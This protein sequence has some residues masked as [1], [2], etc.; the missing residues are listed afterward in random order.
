MKIQYLLSTIIICLAGCQN[1]SS[2]EQILPEYNPE[3][4]CY[5]TVINNGVSAVELDRSR[6]RNLYCLS[7]SSPSSVSI[8]P[9]E[10]KTIPI[11]IEVPQVIRGMLANKEVKFFTYPNDTTRLITD[12]Q[13]IELE[14]KYTIENAYLEN[15][16]KLRRELDEENAQWLNQDSLS[17]DGAIQLLKKTYNTEINLLHDTQGLN[18][19]FRSTALLDAQYSAFNMY[20][21][22]MNSLSRR[23]KNKNSKYSP[24]NFPFLDSL[25]LKNPYMVYSDRALE[26]IH[27][28][29]TDLNISFANSQYQ[30]E[31]AAGSSKPNSSKSYFFIDLLQLDTALVKMLGERNY[32]YFNLQRARRMMRQLDDQDFK[33]YVAKFK[34]IKPDSRFAEVLN[35]MVDNI[36]LKAG[37]LF[38]QITFL[39]HEDKTFKM[40]DLTGKIVLVNFWGTWCAPCVELIPAEQELHHKLADEPFEILNICV[41]CQEVP[42]KEMV[43]EKK[44][45]GVHVIADMEWNV[46][47]SR[48]YGIRAFPTYTLLDEEGKVIT[49]NTH[50]PGVPELEDLIREKLPEG[51]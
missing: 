37:D 4:K 44:M 11:M 42:W 25:D 23:F 17:Q 20:M 1:Q 19:L 2:H 13:L 12:G 43:R 24:R 51:D 16:D 26:F 29:R 21:Y 32:D 22:L 9:G 38:P 50:R 27:L 36:P 10:S 35:L 48:D 8:Q 47:F 14:G 6:F 5:V 39:D 45:S 33:A 28:Y 34:K 40:Q 49:N 3:G 15:R 7:S 41:N 18:S 46:K 30:R 31:V